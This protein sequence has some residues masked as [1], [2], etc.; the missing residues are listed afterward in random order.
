MKKGAGWCPWVTAFRQNPVKAENRRNPLALRQ[1]HI[2]K[3]F[4]VT[5]KPE[6]KSYEVMDTKLSGFGVRVSPKGKIAYIIRWSLRARDGRE[7]IGAFPKM[8]VA[9]GRKKAADHLG[10][11]ARGEDP[12]TE[13]KRLRKAQTMR[14]FLKEWLAKHVARLA[15]KTIKDYTRVVN[16][17]L[18]P[19][20]GSRM[21]ADIGQKDALE[22]HQ[23]LAAHPRSANFA[24]SVLSSSLS[25]AEEWKQRPRNSNPCLDII[26]FEEDERTRALTEAE[27]AAF[28]VWLDRNEE[29]H[30]LAVAQLRF[31]LM[32]GARLG[33][34]QKLEWEWVDLD[35]GVISIPK[36]QHKTGK[37]TKKNRLVG[38]GPHSVALLKEREER[39]V[40][41]WV[42]PGKN[43][44]YK[45][46]ESWWQRR[47]ATE[48]AEMGLGDFRIHDLRHSFATMA[49][50]KG[51]DLDDVG[52]LLGHT[53][54][55]QTRRYAHIA[56]KKLREDVGVVEAGLAGPRT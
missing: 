36:T 7:T 38:L 20:L 32:T 18:I 44:P 52:D 31:L 1:N 3:E 49:R 9:A 43:G 47:H 34:A 28:A 2:L 10:M 54:S 55:R 51:L 56:A 25:S 50:Q 24:L 23:S 53:T 41:K 22:I 8:P 5:L 39:K 13:K 16:K 11:V 29:K 17:V 42:F 30:S 35:G 26:R 48:L 4:L 27:A 33:E 21:V 19:A 46:L 14:E 6:E 12:R 40:S 15:K 45:G 37:K